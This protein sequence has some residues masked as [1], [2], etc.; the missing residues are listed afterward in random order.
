MEKDVSWINSRKNNLNLQF[1]QC[2]QTVPFTQFCFELVLM[3][4]LKLDVATRFVVK[5]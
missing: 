3:S 5:A 1:L 4:T 2:K